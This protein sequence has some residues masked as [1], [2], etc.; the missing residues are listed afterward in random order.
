VQS[1]EKLKKEFVDLGANSAWLDANIENL[2]SNQKGGIIATPDQMIRGGFV[3]R[4]DDLF[5]ARTP[6]WEI[7]S[8][9]YQRY[10]AG[11]G[12]KNLVEVIPQSNAVAMSPQLDVR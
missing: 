9:F 4:V 10:G 11:E 1:K 2:T 6:V 3:Q 8:V 5:F 7:P 12:S